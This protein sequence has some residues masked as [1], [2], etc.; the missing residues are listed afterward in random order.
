MINDFRFKMDEEISLISEMAARF[1][2]R[3]YW[4]YIAKLISKLKKYKHFE[5]DLIHFERT[6]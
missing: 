3:T 5:Q 2:D 6:R 4:H 1:V